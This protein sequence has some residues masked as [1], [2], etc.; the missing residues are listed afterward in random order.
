MKLYIVEDDE[1]LARGMRYTLEQEGFEVQCFDGAA[2]SRR[3][4]ER[5]LPEL[6]ILDWNLPD[7]D[8]LELCRWL[9]SV[10]Q[11]TV[12]MVPA[13]D[14]EMD[15]VICL[16]EGVDDYVAKPFSLAVLKARVRALLRRFRSQEEGGAC[17]S[18]GDIRLSEKERKV[19]KAGGELELSR[20]EY[21]LLHYFLENKNQV[22]LKEQFL[23][24][25][26]DG[27]FVEENTLAASIRRL[28][29]KVEEDPAHPRYIKTVHGMGYLWE[30]QK[31]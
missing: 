14:M 27:D 8:G 12:L 26:W 31:S 19:W 20:V 22:L 7:G 21:K 24:R 30:D 18:S 15:Q 28:R 2:Q 25:V 29:L 13:R 17:L 11:V 1:A 4:L 10:S 23:E 9:K 16:E 3:A 5:E 6:L